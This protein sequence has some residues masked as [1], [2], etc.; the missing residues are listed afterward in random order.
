MPKII[1]KNSNLNKDTLK[2]ILENEY[3]D[4]GYKIS[5]SEFVI[6]SG[7]IMEKS[8]L[9]CFGVGIKKKDNDVILTVNGTF[10]GFFLKK[11]NQ[12]IML[13]LCILSILFFKLPIMLFGAF[14]LIIY[15]LK[16]K[17]IQ[18]EVESFIKSDRFKQ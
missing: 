4:Q 18:K 10:G 12:I 7:W 6:G 1:L 8:F 9:E 5:E 3:S 15:F 13:V 16:W 11:I 14:V 2:T 17:A